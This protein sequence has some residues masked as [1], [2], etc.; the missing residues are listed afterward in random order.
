M[1]ARVLF[2]DFILAIHRVLQSEFS[3]KE[4][5]AEEITISVPTVKGSLVLHF[6]ELVQQSE[7]L[8]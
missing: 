1:L 7:L 6:I 4:Y 5:L 2:H 3:L 8:I